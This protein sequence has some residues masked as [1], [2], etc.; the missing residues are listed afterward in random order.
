MATIIVIGSV[1]G[2]V[3]V[4]VTII[5]GGI[6]FIKWKIK[7]KEKKRIKD[8]EKELETKEEENKRLEGENEKYEIKT[9]NFRMTRNNY[10]MR[11]KQRDNIIKEHKERNDFLQNRH[12]YNFDKYKTD[13]YKF[14]N[15]NLKEI[16]NYDGKASVD[17]KNSE[18]TLK[19]MKSFYKDNFDFL[20]LE[21]YLKLLDDITIFLND[22]HNDK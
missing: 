4:S 19:N 17:N 2:V 7:R 3:A 18:N 9:S 20:S 10:E 8:L 6:S 5:K 13:L 12:I 14:I 21:K 15:E 11:L 22:R 16:L 1:A